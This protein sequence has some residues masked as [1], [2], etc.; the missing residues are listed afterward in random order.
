MKVQF[1][2]SNYFKGKWT[3]TTQDTM[4]KYLN[5]AFVAPPNDVIEKICRPWEYLIRKGLLEIRI[6]QNKKGDNR[7]IFFTMNPLALYEV[8]KLDPECVQYLMSQITIRR[9]FPNLTIFPTDVTIKYDTPKILKA[10]LLQ[11]CEYNYHRKYSFPYHKLTHMELHAYQDQNI[12][13]MIERDRVPVTITYSSAYNC[14]IELPENS[15]SIYCGA[16]KGSLWAPPSHRI[17]KTVDVLGGVLAD[18]MGLG[19]TL[20]FLTMAV[21]TRL[22]TWKV[23]DDRFYSRATLIVLPDHLCGQWE[24]MIMGNAKL[25]IKA[26]FKESAK[27][28]V[29]HMLTLA[30][31]KQYSMKDLLEADFVVTSFKHLLRPTIPDPFETK[32]DSPYHLRA[33]LSAKRKEFFA[34]VQKNPK[35]LEEKGASLFLVT[36]YH[37]VI[38]EIQE[39]TKDKYSPKPTMDGGIIKRQPI[40]EDLLLLLD[41]PRRWVLS[42]TPFEDDP[43]WTNDLGFILRYLIGEPDALCA[44]LKKD[45]LEQ[46]AKLFRRNTKAST[47]REVKLPPIEESVI[48]IPFSLEERIRYDAY[49]AD[50]NYKVTDPEIQNLLCS[51]NMTSEETSDKAKSSRKILQELK[52]KH[53]NDYQVLRDRIVKYKKDQKKISARLDRLG[54]QHELAPDSDKEDHLSDSEPEIDSDRRR[55]KGHRR[56]SDSDSDSDYSSSESEGE[57]I[58]IATSNT[59]NN[60]KNRVKKDKKKKKKNNDDSSSS[61]SDDAEDSDDENTQENNMSADQAKNQLNFVKENLTNC[62]E[63][64]KGK[65]SSIRYLRT[66]GKQLRSKKIDC[67]LCKDKINKNSMGMTCCGHMF[68]HECIIKSY[69]QKTR[70]PICQTNLDRMGGIFRIASESK[71]EDVKKYGSKLL[72]L[73]KLMKNIREKKEKV[74]LFAH[75]TEFLKRISAVLDEQ[76]IGNVFVQGAASQRN[77]ALQKFR[78][79]DSDTC[80]IMMSMQDSA[81]GADLTV[82]KYIIILDTI[83]GKE[84]FTTEA[85]AVA[86]L[87]RLGQTAKKVKIW[88]LV[89]ENTIEDEALEKLFDNSEDGNVQKDNV[90]SASSATGSSGT[91]KKDTSSEK[92]GKNTKKNKSNSDSESDDSSSSDSDSDSDNGGGNRKRSTRLQSN[93]SSSSSDDDN[94]RNRRSGG[95]SLIDRNDLR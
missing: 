95:R 47:Y 64:A 51:P 59:Q 44:V 76:K 41:A 49:I 87:A 32:G 38:D 5:D 60:L 63:Q 52:Q 57:E 10:A 90:T 28:K 83:P 58:I 8:R 6:F 69:R 74:L 80:A 68:C 53:K 70:C 14:A 15:G 9:I 93:V 85:Q 26:Y 72:Y 21:G 20:T 86:R 17:D 3:P 23:I 16:D 4:D 11:T 27:I 39:A 92:K 43:R 71:K 75:N 24:D 31:Y 18:E 65:I 67:P 46:I 78:D 35:L 66:I 89:M 40:L 1:L 48:K 12:V 2:F 7:T 36:W 77:A 56:G 42:G 79:K 82:A 94:D 25:G 88:R 73:I 33:Q 62:R 13:W 55:R 84:R 81:A 54:R 19:K 22:Q 30:N 45:S 50:K 34:A 61:S 91:S 29:I 37:M